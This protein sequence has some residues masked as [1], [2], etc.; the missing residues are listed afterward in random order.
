MANDRPPFD[1]RPRSI[2]PLAA[3]DARPKAAPSEAPPREARDTDIS[4]LSP[5]GEYEVHDSE[6]TPL[7]SPYSLKA[8]SE[9]LDKVF[10][11]AGSAA[12][13]AIATRGE[14]KTLTEALQ[15]LAR[16][17]TALE[18]SGR[19]APLLIS[20]LAIGGVLWLAFELQRLQMQLQALMHQ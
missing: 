6:K 17:V 19:W 10:A 2:T 9:K 11:A 5:S 8:I 12:S 18:V 15:A 7:E 13:E 3:F 20:S 1:P 4:E 14:V 16:R